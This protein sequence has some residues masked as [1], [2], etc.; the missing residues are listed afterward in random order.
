MAETSQVPWQPRRH[1]YY[2]RKIAD[3]LITHIAIYRALKR[4]TFARPST[5]YKHLLTKV[6]FQQVFNI[7]LL[8]AHD[9]P[10]KRPFQIPRFSSKSLSQKRKN[11]NWECKKITLSSV[12]K[13]RLSFC[14]C[15]SF[16]NFAPHFDLF[17]T[18][19]KNQRLRRS[20]PIFS[21]NQYHFPVKKLL[22]FQKF[23]VRTV[24]NR[25]SN[26]PF[27]ETLLLRIARFRAILAQVR[28][29]LCRAG[30]AGGVVRGV[31]SKTERSMLYLLFCRIVGVKARSCVFIC[32]KK[33]AKK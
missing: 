25:R 19:S 6:S 11:P 14:S 7:R 31:Y 30:S 21:Q 4:L 9:R 20:L 5:T 17:A 1:L 8:L 16:V 24:P 27:F 26:A 32:T 18:L 2:P 28:S 12:P 15:Y 23:F 13:S 22:K 3:S 29:F 33:Y 10:S